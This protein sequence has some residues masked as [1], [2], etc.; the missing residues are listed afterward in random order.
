MAAGGVVAGMA[1]VCAGLLEYKL[2]ETYSPVPSNNGAEMILINTLPC[3]LQVQIWGEEP[4]S[5]PNGQ[6]LT[7]ADLQVENFTTVDLLVNSPETCGGELWKQSMQ[8]E[9]EVRAGEVCNKK[10]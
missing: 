10:L 8:R 7:I 6:M 9:V 3:D 4:R 2:Q 5:L 1:F